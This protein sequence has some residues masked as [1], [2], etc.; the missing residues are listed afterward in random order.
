MSDKRKQNQQVQKFGG[1]GPRHHM[2]AGAPATVKDR[3][4]ILLR[5]WNYLKVYRIALLGIALLVAIN[6]GRSSAD[7]LLPECGL[8]F[9][10]LRCLSLHQV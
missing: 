3:R 9:E 8:L 5:L 1:F 7:A 2:F 6:T 4:G 10:Y